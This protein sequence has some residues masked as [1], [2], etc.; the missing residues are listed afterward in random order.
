[1]RAARSTDQACL[2]IKGV[3][4]GDPRRSGRWRRKS[5]GLR[6]GRRPH[7]SFDSIGSRDRGNKGPREQEGRD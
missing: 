4:R 2:L 5:G 7:G 1:L 6:T 3:E